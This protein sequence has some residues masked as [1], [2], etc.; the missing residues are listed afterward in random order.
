LVV[1]I[2]FAGQKKRK[3][4]LIFFKQVTIV[5]KDYDRFVALFKQQ[6]ASQKIG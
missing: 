2:T 5:Q 4:M 3:Q 1:L 6:S